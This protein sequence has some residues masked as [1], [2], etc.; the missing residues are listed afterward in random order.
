MLLSSTFVHIPRTGG[1]S[2]RNTHNFSDIWHSYTS[3]VPTTCNV[4]TSLRNETDRY[5]SEWNFYGR[6]F[7]AK[8]KSVKGWIPKSRPKTFDLFAKDRTTHNTMVRILSGCQLYDVGCDVTEDTVERIYQKIKEG[9]IRL[10]DPG[11]E[12]MHANRHLCSKEE[13]KIA[14]RVNVLDRLL[15]EKLRQNARNPN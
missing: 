4:I 6:H 13:M 14:Y 12:I 15:L 9:C 11:H 3:P 1:I 7:F 8:N 2:I 10:I 5:C